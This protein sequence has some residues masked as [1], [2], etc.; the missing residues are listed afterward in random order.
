MSSNQ[1]KMVTLAATCGHVNEP[2]RHDSAQCAK[3]F[4]RCEDDG[5]G[6]YNEVFKILHYNLRP[7]KKRNHKNHKGPPDNFRKIFQHF[8]SPIVKLRS[9]RGF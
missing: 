3:D 8:F 5:A 2:I 6:G 9:V 1:Y 7:K 4:L